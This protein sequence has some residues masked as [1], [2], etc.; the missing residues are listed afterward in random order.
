MSDDPA[1][2]KLVQTIAPTPLSRAQSIEFRAYRSFRFRVDFGP[3]AVIA[4]MSF[5]VQIEVRHS[6]DASVE[7]TVCLSVAVMGSIAVKVGG[8]TIRVGW[9]TFLSHP[10]A[11][12]PPR[13]AAAP[14]M[15][16][17]P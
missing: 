12:E 13:L 16:P 14:L 11:C 5:S 3:V 1:G 4:A 10:L 15:L 7:P 2:W 6:E 9:S 17:K 8:Y